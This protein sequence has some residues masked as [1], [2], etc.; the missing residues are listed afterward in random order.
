MKFSSPLFGVF[1]SLYLKTQCVFYICPCLLLHPAWCPLQMSSGFFAFATPILF[2]IADGNVKKGP[3][4]D[5]LVMCTYCP[6]IIGLL[7]L[8][9]GQFSECGMGLNPCRFECLMGDAG[10]RT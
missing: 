8:L 9:L 7:S 2:Q 1:F 3:K 4:N 10:N 6:S 5:L